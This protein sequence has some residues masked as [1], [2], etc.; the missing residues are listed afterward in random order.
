MK[1][2]KK[3]GV[4]G[5]FYTSRI[6]YMKKVKWGDDEEKVTIL[7][8][9]IFFA[10]G[11]SATHHTH[12][13]RRPK[14]WGRQRTPERIMKEWRSRGRDKNNKDKTRTMTTIATRNEHSSYNLEDLRR[15]IQEDLHS[16]LL[17]Y[18]K[19]YNIQ[20]QPTSSITLMD[21]KEPFL[22]GRA[23]IERESGEG[24]KCG[25]GETNWCGL[26]Y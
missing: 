9:V 6:K 7:L 11:S 22:I 3:N 26:L 8:T 1:K 15:K 23:G 24:K 20:Q 5:G 10:A 21:W 16:L 25:L 2:K 14:S 19:N 17:P 4:K 13:H 18:N 12:T